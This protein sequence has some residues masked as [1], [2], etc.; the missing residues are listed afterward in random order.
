[1]YNI[2]RAHRRGEMCVCVCVCVYQCALLLDFYGLE[3]WTWLSW[4]FYKVTIRWSSC[5]DPAVAGSLWNFCCQPSVSHRM[6]D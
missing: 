4:A 1:M 2:H 5:E 3:A 6:L